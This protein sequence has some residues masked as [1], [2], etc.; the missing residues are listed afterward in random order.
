MPPFT[1]LIAVSGIT[2]AI[3]STDY[4]RRVAECVEAARILLAA[5]GRAD[6]P[7]RLAEVS[8][9]DYARHRAGLPSPLDRRA[10]HFFS[11]MERVRE[12]QQAWGRGDL[13]AFGRRVT[14]SG[15]SSIENYECGCRPMID[16][17]ELLVAAPG[18]Y[19]AR[20]SGAGFRGCCV[21]LVDPPRAESAAAS[22]REAYSRMH[23]ELA[24]RS[25]AFVCH[26][27]DGARLL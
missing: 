6:A 19:G 23:P 27:A 2:Q 12:G 17:Y 4:N 18:V 20:F 5:A 16:L 24:G 13:V 9:G 11:E 15:R 26:T 8:P 1:I 3:V 25:H 14:E 21:A 22:V 7:A 10:A